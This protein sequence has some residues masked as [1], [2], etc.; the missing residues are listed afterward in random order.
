MTADTAVVRARLAGRDDGLDRRARSRPRDAPARAG[1]RG[2]DVAAIR[3]RHLRDGSWPHVGEGGARGIRARGRRHQPPGRHR[4]GHRAAGRGRR[5]RSAGSSR[6]TSTG[7]PSRPSVTA[8][9]L[10]CDD[11]TAGRDPA[12]PCGRTHG[13]RDGWGGRG[14]LAAG[15]Q[16]RGCW[17]TTRCSWSAGPAGCPA[18]KPPTSGLGPRAWPPAAR[19][20]RAASRTASSTATSPPTRSSSVRWGRSSSTGRTG[21]SRT[22]SCRPRRCSA[23]RRQ[24]GGDGAT[25]GGLPRAVARCRD[26]VTEAAVAGRWPPPG[27]SIR[28]TWPPCTPSGSCRPSGGASENAQRRPARSGRSCPDDPPSDPGRGAVRGPRPCR[29]AGGRDWSEADRLRAE[30]EAAGW[31]IADRGTDFAL[32]PAAPADLADGERVRYGC[33]GSVP[34]RFEEPA[35]GLATIV[36]IATDWPDDLARAMAALARNV[37]RGTSVVIVADG[38]SAEQATALE[39]LR[40]A[41]RAPDAPVRSSGPAN[42][43]AMRQR[44]TSAYA[45]RAARS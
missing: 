14:A 3:G 5:S 9:R 23:M 24:R 18:R 12:R 29:G 31:K 17:T 36:L 34:S 15:R 8:R 45:G 4:S 30:I 25:S 43:S 11:V 37:A 41:R 2:A 19:S 7:P 38:P 39:A 44:S 26:R 10:A 16:S 40:D 42:G 13:A 35:T 32:T 22:H 28:S 6:S 20:R 27:S 33:S 21:R 1:P